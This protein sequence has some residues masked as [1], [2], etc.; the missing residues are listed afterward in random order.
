MYI[1]T[2]QL[3]FN[4]ARSAYR[5]RICC[6]SRWIAAITAFCDSTQK[7]NAAFHYD[8]C[9]PTS[10][11]SAWSSGRKSD[12]RLC[13]PTEACAMPT[14]ERCCCQHAGT[15]VKLAVLA[16]TQCTWSCV[17][18][19]NRHLSVH[20]DASAAASNVFDPILDHELPART[21]ASPFA[22]LTVLPQLL[23][24]RCR[25]LSMRNRQQA[26]HRPHTL[27][28]D[29]VLHPHADPRYRCL[30]PTAAAV[31]PARAASS[32]WHAHHFPALLRS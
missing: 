28:I 21:R 20:H 9:G 10:H 11:S 3:Y 8:A 13:T 12:H 18:S 5:T 31:A 23:R 27:T 19:C 1:N 29:R 14:S 32:Q 15:E 25:L 30:G 2:S 24:P 17:S 7:Y 26:L 22:M 4:R 6:R 16:R